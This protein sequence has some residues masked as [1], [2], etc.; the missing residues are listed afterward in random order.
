MINIDCIISADGIINASI[1][2]DLAINANVTKDL[3]INLIGIGV[4]KGGTEGQMLVK[5][6]NQDYNT[7]WTSVI[8][9]GTF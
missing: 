6:D 7:K 5:A 2:N 1:N 8:D 4:P 9:G 3:A